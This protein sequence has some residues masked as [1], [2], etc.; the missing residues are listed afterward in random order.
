MPAVCGASCA[1]LQGVKGCYSLQWSG[2]LKYSE[3]IVL[4]I[5]QTLE[6]KVSMFTKLLRPKLNSFIDLQDITQVKINITFLQVLLLVPTARPQKS[7]YLSQQE[8]SLEVVVTC[9]SI[10][11]K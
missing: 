8:R 3:Y 11:V 7:V 10:L 1:H 4:C 2:I 5:C 6:C 9:I